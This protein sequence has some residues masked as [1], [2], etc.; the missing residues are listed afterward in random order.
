MSGRIFSKN[1]PVDTIKAQEIQTKIIIDIKNIYPLHEV[2]PIGSVGR[3]EM[4]YMHND[5]DIA[6][7]AENIDELH[8]IISSIFE[9]AV[10]KESL[11]VVSIP[12]EYEEGKTIQV[13]FIL[14]TNPEW[15]KFRYYCPDYSKGES[16]YKVG[17]KIMLTNLLLNHCYDI[18]YDLNED[19]KYLHAMFDYSP[20]GLYVTSFSISNDG[21]YVSSNKFVTD[22]PS[23]IPLMLFGLEGR[24]EWMNTVES[25]W[26]AIHSE[27]FQY[28]DRLYYIE[29]NWFL[30]CFKKGWTSIRPE[31]FKLEY[32]T[33]DEIHTAMLE[34]VGIHNINRFFNSDE[35]NI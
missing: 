3:R 22:D 8:N 9:D 4:T 2:I 30:N 6:V 24:M 26:D 13:D 15:T 18:L 12:Y 23:D 27:H 28:K 1:C 14:I 32:C 25:I 10:V 35:K 17:P 19:P 31:D 29:R 11:Y 21:A 33:L 34:Y 5:I 16:K 7:E 20:I